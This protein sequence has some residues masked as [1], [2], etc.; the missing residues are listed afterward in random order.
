MRGDGEFN[1][2]NVLAAVGSFMPLGP[3]P[4]P[5]APACSLQSNAGR[6]QLFSL[7]DRVMLDYGII[8][9]L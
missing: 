2:E 4:T 9:R 5:Y 8:R 1:V 6:F 3:P 7:T